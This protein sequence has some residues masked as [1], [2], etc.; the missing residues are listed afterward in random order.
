MHF[1]FQESFILKIPLN[2]F[3]YCSSF[4]FYT[5]TWYQIKHCC[6]KS[7]IW[8]ITIYFLISP[9]SLLYVDILSYLHLFKLFQ[10][11]FQE[12]LSG[13]PYSRVSLLHLVQLSGLPIGS[14]A[15]A[16]F[17]TLSHYHT[18]IFPLELW[19]KLVIPAN[20]NLTWRYNTPPDLYTALDA[21]Q[22]LWLLD[23]WLQC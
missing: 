18:P 10:A 4:Q 6:L 15:T 7:K 16:L 12:R 19:F 1:C 8:P 14:W 20:T 9:K 2:W 17:P 11:L 22:S 3:Q 21:T 23:T 5:M 13:R